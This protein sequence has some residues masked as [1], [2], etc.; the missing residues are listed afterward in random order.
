MKNQL[1]GYMELVKNFMRKH[2]LLFLSVKVLKLLIVLFLFSCGSSQD[3]AKLPDTILIDSLPG[4]SPADSIIFRN[5]EEE[6]EKE[7]EEN[8]NPMVPEEG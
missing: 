4:N 2:Y 8:S 5:D 1:Q 6:E 7:E 3:P